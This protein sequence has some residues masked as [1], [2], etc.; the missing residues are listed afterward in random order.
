MN[1]YNA[2]IDAHGIG[3]CNIDAPVS[4]ASMTISTTVGSGYTGQINTGG[5]TMTIS[6]GLT[7][8]AGSF[9]ANAS[10]ITWVAGDV[11][12]ASGTYIANISLP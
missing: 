10:S 7:M 2:V 3:T 11:I 9:K 12:I 8:N 4:I 5:N 6:G 1:G